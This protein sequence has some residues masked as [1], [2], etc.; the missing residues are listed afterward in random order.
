MINY[1]LYMKKFLNRKIV[2]GIFSVS[3]IGSA[4]PA[5]YQDITYGHQ[6]TWT[7]YGMMLVGVLYLIESVLWT[8]D[9]WKK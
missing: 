9:I 6:G 1:L 2:K 5:I 7:H 3:I 4:L 8:M